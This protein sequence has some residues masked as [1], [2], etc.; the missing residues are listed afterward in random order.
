MSNFKELSLPMQKMVIDFYHELRNS[1]PSLYMK[2]IVS[3]VFDE[4]FDNIF[5]S[6]ELLYNGRKVVFLP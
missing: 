5:K 1:L 2:L 6:E 3:K 4:Y